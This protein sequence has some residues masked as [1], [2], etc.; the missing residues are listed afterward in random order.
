MKRFLL[1]LFGCYLIGTAIIFL[2]VMPI[3]WKTSTTVVAVM[4]VLADIAT[5]YMAFSVFNYRKR[6]I[7]G[8]KR[9]MTL[10]VFKIFYTV[11]TVVSF[12]IAKSLTSDLI[13]RLVGLL[14]L[15]LFYAPVDMLAR[16]HRFL[17][18]R[19][20]AAVSQPGLIQ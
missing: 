1:F 3:I 4:I 5:F 12:I 2:I 8:V 18:Y 11:L 6:L 13:D 20:S 17:K 15:S 9:F 19:H 14:F 7:N 10:T 16:A